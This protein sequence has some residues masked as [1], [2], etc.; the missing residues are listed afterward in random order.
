MADEREKRPRGR[1]QDDRDREP[2]STFDERVVDIGRTAK[3]VKGGRHFGFRAVVV[4]GDNKGT[5][6]VGVGKAREVPDAVRKGTEKARKAMKPVSLAENTIPHPVTA[7][8]G[9]SQVMLKPATPGTGVIAGGGVRAVLEC[10]GVRDV[11]TKSLGSSN[12][13]N[14]VRATLLALGEMKNV[15]AESKKRGKTAGELLPPWR[16]NNGSAN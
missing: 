15:E 12:K 3:V 7:K 9:A 11:L 4:V 5:V 1:R 8:F 13:L 16:K 14:V 6:G 2:E 10:A